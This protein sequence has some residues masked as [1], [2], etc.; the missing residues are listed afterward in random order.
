MIDLAAWLLEQIAEDEAVA[1]AVDTIAPWTARRIHTGEGELVPFGLDLWIA[2]AIHIATFDPA[3][4]LAECAAKRAI[5]AIHGS[6][7]SG[8]GPGYE[9]SADM[10]D[11]PCLTL[12]LL[13]A[14]FAD[15][16]GFDS[17]WKVET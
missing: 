6:T 5:V 13:A 7:E 8:Y 14:P 16:P 11:Y 17:A 10:N 2:D 3:R 12:R 4:V 1:R 9:C 15:R